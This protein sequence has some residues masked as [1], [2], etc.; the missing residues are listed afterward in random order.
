[1]IVEEF[2]NGG[3]V[4]EP[5][6][7]H[8]ERHFKQLVPREG[9]LPKEFKEQGWTLEAPYRGQESEL[10]WACGWTTYE[11][12]FG[13]SPRI[14]IMQA[15]DNAG[16]WSLGS[17]WLIRDEPNNDFLGND[18]ITWEFLNKQ[19]NLNIPLVKEMRILTDPADSVQ[20]RLM[21][22]AQGKMLGSIWTTLSPEQKAS[23]R[24]Q[25]VDILKQLR[26]FTAPFPQKV[27][28]D[29]LDDHLLCLC[30]RHPPTCYKMGFTE[31]EWLEDVSPA[32]RDG[33]ARVHKTKDLKIIE[34]KLQEIKD[35][36]P[37]GGPYVLT[38]GDLNLTNIIVQDDKIEAIIDWE[39]AGYYPWWGETYLSV[40]YGDDNSDDLLESVW[41]RVHSDLDPES[42][43]FRA[44]IHNLVPLRLAFQE[45]RGFTTKLKRLE[46][47]S[48]V[49]PSA[50]A[51]RMVA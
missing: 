47:V 26:Q 30:R 28:G 36:F 15:R 37:R 1:M 23:Y 38:H 5:H 14:R 29:Q 43:T 20:F 8:P 3:E 11:Q 40:M 42:K 10:C 39:M 50:N 33:L 49:P 35:N 31:E 41:G 13:Y 6:Y 46:R 2:E 27:N 34:Q 4:I 25:M 19:P 7:A 16:L 21:S 24:D 18:Y 44:L 48:C 32:L 12:R 17:K 9:G 45:S 22:R 51:G